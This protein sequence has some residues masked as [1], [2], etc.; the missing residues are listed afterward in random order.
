MSGFVDTVAKAS[1]VTKIDSNQPAHRFDADKRIDA[2]KT[3]SN[4]SKEKRFDPDKRIDVIK[5]IFLYLA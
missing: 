1:E 2:E 3:E 5:S 4:D